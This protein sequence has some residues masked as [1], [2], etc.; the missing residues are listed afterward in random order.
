MCEN[1]LELL[2]ENDLE[3]DLSVRQD[4]DSVAEVEGYIEEEEEEVFVVDVVLDEEEILEVEAEEFSEE[5]SSSDDHY[6]SHDLTADVT[7]EYDTADLQL[8]V[9]PQNAGSASIDDLKEIS[10]KFIT[11]SVSEKVINK[12]SKSILSK[13]QSYSSIN[14]FV[15]LL[16]VIFIILFIVFLMN[17]IF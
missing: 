6:N 14:I 8:N 2:R 7:A 17:I 12:E 15:L 10:N 9:N 5:E 1:C 4:C 13:L 16:F 11:D 3:K